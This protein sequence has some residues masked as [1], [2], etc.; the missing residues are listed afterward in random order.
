[1]AENKISAVNFLPEY[2]KTSKNV[3]FLNSTIDQLIQKP[4]LKS[5][6]G[7]I[8][9]QQT[10]TYKSSDVFL[11]TGNPY[12]LDPALILQDKVGN[13]TDTQGFD[14][15][16]NEI[17]AKGGITN[18]LDRLLRTKFYSY[19]PHVDWDKLVNYQN[20]YWMPYGPE[21]LEIPTN[22]LD[23]AY[24]IEG[25]QYVEVSVLLPD[26]S[27][28]TV[29]LSNGML[30]TFCGQEIDYYYQNREFFVEGVGTSIRLIPYD[31]LLISETFLSPY[32]DGFDSNLYDQIP[33]D[34]DRELPNIK[35]EYVTIN[36]S[37][38][39]LNPWSRYNRWV[40][41]DVIRQS[42]ELNG[43]VPNFS[44]GRAQRPIIEFN[45]DIKLYNFGDKGILPV[46]LIDSENID[47]FST[48]EGSTDPVYIDGVLVEHG[49]R[50]IFNAVN[51]EGIRGKVYEVVYV[52]QSGLPTLTLNPTYEPTSGDSITVLLGDTYNATEWWYDGDVWQYAQQKET[53][54]QAPLFDLFDNSGNSYGD[55]NY[56]LSDFTGNKIFS[57]AV[58]SGINDQYL[59]FPIA[60]KVVNTIGS[61]LFDNALCNGTITISQLSQPTFTISTNL[62]YI[63]IGNE[64]KNAW[65]DGVDYPIPLISSTATGILSYYEEPLSLTNN[66]LN[67]LSSQFTISELS[68]HVNSM[69]NRLPASQYALRDLGDYSNY[70]TALISS[71]NPISFAQMFLGQKEHDLIFALQ[72][73]AENYNNFKNGVLN[74]CSLISDQLTP[75][76]AVDLILTELNQDKVYNNSYYL[77]DMVGYGPPEVVRTWTVNHLTINNPSFPLSEDFEIGRAHV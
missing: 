47:P 45:A 38:R 57:Y 41:K 53:L 44:E 22:G 49:H 56:Y 67:G 15:F 20:Y 68:Q 70:G 21:L 30:I 52:I 32:P 33:Y 3:K 34:N 39:D 25:H 46:D 61:I 73:S 18:D 51:F 55:K 59:E 29:E 65:V 5:V 72:K 64:Y 10:P 14:D 16:V 62:T 11:A 17:A 48:I 24:D 6:D 12:H 36:R 2:L 26:G 4:K 77:S 63:K 60:Y 28:E 23:V 27:E 74:K 13:V 19:T 69:V 35:Q 58:G 75:I 40:H 7:Y 76:E 9:S 71:K 1:M 66:P 42:A 43:V 8:G 37:S 54:N 50:V 31:S